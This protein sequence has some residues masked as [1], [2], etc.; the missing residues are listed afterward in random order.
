MRH[1]FVA[2]AANDASTWNRVTKRCSK[3]WTWPRSA[4]GVAMKVAEQAVEGV[5]VR[6]KPCCA[7]WVSS[8]AKKELSVPF[9]AYNYYWNCIVLINFI[10]IFLRWCNSGT[11]CYYVTWHCAAQNC[12][13]LCATILHCTLPASAGWCVHNLCS[14]LRSSL[15]FVVVSR[16]AVLSDLCFVSQILEFEVWLG[17]SECVDVTLELYSLA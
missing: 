4:C 14:H 10:P 7:A 2:K 5:E 9:L 6:Q 17:S 12:L 1:E 13:N 8:T 15:R 3:K 16:Y 11:L